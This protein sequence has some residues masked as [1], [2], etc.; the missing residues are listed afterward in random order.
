MTILPADGTITA[1][2]GPTNTGKT[3]RAVQRML[4]HRSGMIGLPLRLLARE[5]YD[6]ITA[7]KGEQAVALVTGEE[8]R[9]PAN[10]K[11]F[12]CT[13]EAM[14]VDRPVNFLAV[15]EIQLAGD[16]NRGHVFTD[17]LLHARGMRE[18]MFLGSDTI[19]PLLE[20]LV[21]T[22]QI[23]RQPR[24]SK[25][26]HLGYR[27]L[28][29]LP[30]RTA[31]VA[32]SAAEVYV[33]A[34]R[35][36][37][38]HGGTAVVLG[39]L[40]PRTRNAQVAMYQ[41]GE[42]PY[43]VAT[44]AIGMGLNMDIEHV[45]F[46]AFRKF[47]GT[48][49][50]GLTPAETAQIAGRAGRF[51][52]DGTFG[53][54]GELGELDPDVVHAVESHSFAPLKRLW[55]RSS[56]LDFSSIDALRESL[57][58]RPPAGFLA[59][60]REEED[61]RALQAL[62]GMPEVRLAVHG[63]D[64]VRLLWEVCQIPD[65]R[66]LLTD[67]HV[68]LLARIFGHVARSGTIPGAWVGR[69][70]EQLD[71]VDGDLDL[72]MTRLAHVRT[73]TYV[74]SRS[75][76]LDDALGWQAR[77]RAIEDRL[78]DAL[79]AELTQRFVDRRTLALSSF[80]GGAQG[81]SA[82]ASHGALPASGEVRV[83]GYV[84]GTL[85]GLTWTAQDGDRLS[86]R[87]ARE[88]LAG[89]L[90]ERVERAI[91]APHEAYALDDEGQVSWEGGVV[92][93][94]VAGPSVLLPGLK[95]ARHDLLAPSALQ[96]VQRRVTAFVRDWAAAVVA[97]LQSREADALH[98]PAQGLLYALTQGLGVVPAQEAAD[99]VRAIPERDRRVLSRIGV[100]FGVEH[101]WAL[102]LLPGAREH[103]I[104]WR[105]Q[106]GEDRSGGYHRAVGTPIV[107]GIPV[108]VEALEAFAAKARAGA[109]GGTFRTP[110]GLPPSEAA[111]VLDGLGY[112]RQ[113]ELW[114][115]GRRR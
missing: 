87:A 85:L 34:E 60:A 114:T 107:G 33:L 29:A 21:P 48:G 66:K 22:A 28:G 105:T 112:R 65:F 37:A 92:A 70:L 35:L 11:W 101:V 62:A 61:E 49:F 93:R 32:F 47:D 104:L 1:L 4:Q 79:H 27:K 38:R 36:R 96:R 2:L 80:Q 52:R 13:V 108:Q 83:G 103:A 110:D 43:L 58:V 26:S 99:L 12:V 40:S 15:D 25:L 5:V 86:E 20:R 45:A 75:A 14:P 44:D 97:P 54:T 55:W 56:E 30:K 67:A 113:G 8:K 72:L 19:A 51:R 71:R 53:A 69:Q 90:A 88:T 42:V 82:G 63:P 7:E 59:A 73:W 74:S 57:A 98:G 94:L 102:P 16:R 95:M 17:R 3:H 68:Q 46:S 109:R 91:A 77:A 111:A 115:R 10:P 76:W 64:D 81:G 31:I 50:R 84:V 23:E 78:S 39:A 9:I 89:E 100:R 41:A 106:H 6:R 18:T 24:F